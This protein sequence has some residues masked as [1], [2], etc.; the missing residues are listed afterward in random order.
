M[1]VIKFRPD[2]KHRLIDIRQDSEYSDIKSDIRYGL[3]YIEQLEKEL[4]R[5][6]KYIPKKYRQDYGDFS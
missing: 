5:V 1:V 2:L 3:R 6:A 4:L